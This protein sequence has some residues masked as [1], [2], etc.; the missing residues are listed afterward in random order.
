[1]RLSDYDSYYGRPF[2][3]PTNIKQRVAR[4]LAER[5]I[6]FKCDDRVTLLAAES[7]WTLNVWARN[8]QN[9]AW[10]DEIYQLK[11]DFLHAMYALG[12]LKPLSLCQQVIKCHSCERGIYRR[13]YD[14]G[15][16]SY[17]DTCWDCGGTGVYKRVLLYEFHV[18]IGDREF[19]WHQPYD[20]VYF[21]APVPDMYNMVR[22]ADGNLL[23]DIASLPKFKQ[24]RSAP[25]RLSDWQLQRHMLR[26][27]VYVSRFSM[28]S[29]LKLND[30]RSAIRNDIREVVCRLEHGFLQT[31][32]WRIRLAL[33]R[34][35]SVE[36]ELPF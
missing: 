11:S 2:R 14:S 36:E 21:D 5:E 20:R 13:Y 30:W 7:L 1:M 15:D 29:E 25:I 24:P 23:I 16:I 32:K 10:R 35:G 19:V 27:A 3:L 34:M 18:K 31:W 4:K 22:D 17:E 33:S 28:F 8:A 12:Y 9:S 26:L 6:G